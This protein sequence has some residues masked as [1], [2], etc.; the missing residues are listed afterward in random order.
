MRQGICPK[1][2]CAEVYYGSSAD[3]EG[4]NAGSYPAFVEVVAGSDHTTLWL[5]T[6]ICRTCGY[7]ELYVSNQAGLNSLGQAEGWKRAG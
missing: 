3:G 6:Y 7:V 4:L 2:K 1:C 5:G